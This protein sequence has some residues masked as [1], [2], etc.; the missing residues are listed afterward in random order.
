MRLPREA[1]LCQYGMTSRVR[2]AVEDENDPDWTMRN[3]PLREQML[4]VGD[5]E[6]D[7]L[8]RQQDPE[9]QEPWAY[10]VSAFKRMGGCVPQ[11]VPPEGWQ[12]LLLYEA[13]TRW[14]AAGNRDEAAQAA[15]HFTQSANLV[16][17]HPVVQHLMAQYP[18]IVKT[19][20]QRVFETFMYDP[21]T[22]FSPGEGHDICGFQAQDPDDVPP[23]YYLEMIEF[24]YSLKESLKEHG[25]TDVQMTAEAGEPD[26][27]RLNMRR[28]NNAL[29]AVG[30]RQQLGQ[31]VSEIPATREFRIMWRVLQSQSVA[32][33]QGAEIAA[34]IRVKHFLGNRGN[35]G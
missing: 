1:K 29:D 30:V 20:Q 35:N 8:V 3:K 24:P 2:V 6:Y 5:A 12:V 13:L 19:M 31:I 18:C 25:Y 15:R 16:A 22:W 7:A 33:V 26:C 11:A 28:E 34:A 27:Y 9:A 4:P 23:E 32:I 17:V 21:R 14:G 10:A